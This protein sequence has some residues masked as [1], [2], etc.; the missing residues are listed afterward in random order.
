M[1]INEITQ[2]IWRN[3]IQIDL[4]LKFLNIRLENRI[5]KPKKS[6]FD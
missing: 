2:N 6:I 5:I 3:L 4:K 1:D